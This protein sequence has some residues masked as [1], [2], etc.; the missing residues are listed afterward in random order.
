MAWTV[1]ANADAPAPSWVVHPAKI[2]LMHTRLTERTPLMAQALGKHKDVT[3]K[4]MM[5]ASLRNGKGEACAHGRQ[6]K[7]FLIH[8]AKIGQNQNNL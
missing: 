3:V 6:G 5:I 2:T 1:L 4:S 8:P 7:F